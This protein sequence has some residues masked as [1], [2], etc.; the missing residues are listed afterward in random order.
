MNHADHVTLLRGGVLVTEDQPTGR[1]WADLGSG[2]G[3][4][5][6]ALA[7][8][9][10]PDGIIHSVDRDATALDTQRRAMH[11]QFGSRAPQVRYLVADYTRPLVLPPLDGIVMANT[12]HFHHDPVPVV[13]RVA[14]YL[15]P[16]GRLLVIEY[17]TDRGNIWVPHPFSFAA[18]VDIARR[19]GFD[20]TRRLHT[21]PSR[22]LGQIFSAVSQRTVLPDL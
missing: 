19:S 10:G 5:T 3:A 22:F 6:L 1:V 15:K 2:A 8:L 12:L 13:R 21:V 17:D 4:F 18:W 9:L 14:D 16:T 20:T 11:T 7:D